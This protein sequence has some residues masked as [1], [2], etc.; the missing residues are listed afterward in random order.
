MTTTAGE[1]Q[2]R[3]DHRQLICVDRRTKGDEEQ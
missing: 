1:E 3:H 2:E